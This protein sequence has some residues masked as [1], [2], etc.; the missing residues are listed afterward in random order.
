MVL[1]DHQKLLSIC[2][3][4]SSSL[5]LNILLLVMRLAIAKLSFT[6][7]VFYNLLSP[8]GQYWRFFLWLVKAAC[9]KLFE[10]SRQA[11][12]SCFSEQLDSLT[13]FVLSQISFDHFMIEGI[14]YLSFIC[15]WNSCN[16]FIFIELLVNSSS[17]QS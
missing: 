15:R 4:F 8:T 7:M 17:Y 14:T 11:C 9:A 1:H 13:Q 3:S 6:F 10:L 5:C 16:R 12:Q 2:L